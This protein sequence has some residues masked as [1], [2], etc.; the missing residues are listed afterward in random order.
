MAEPHTHT[1]SSDHRSGASPS[2]ERGAMA[3]GRRFG[4]FVV[5]EE[6]GRGGM[7]VVWS[8]YDPQLDRRIALKLVLARGDRQGDARAA[9]RLL[10]E[11]QALARL[12]HP[13]VIAVHDVGIEGE[14]VF[15]AMEYVDGERLDRWCRDR[16]W[17]AIVDAF[18]QAGQG[19]SA[20]HDGG[21]VHRDLKPSNVLVDRS[22]R[23][24]VLDFGLARAI[25]EGTA[26]RDLLEQ[27]DTLADGHAP[28]TA[29]L[30]RGSFTGTPAYASPEQFAGE[31][32]TARSD[33]FGFCV[34]LWECLFGARP[35][36]GE[37][38]SAL[39][40]RVRAGQ[41]D[42]P[43]SSS[44][45]PVWVRRALERGLA[46]DPR[47]RWP[48]MQ[49]LVAILRGDAAVRRRRIGYGLGAIAVVLA[50][51]GG[52]QLHRSELRDACGEEAEVVGTIWNAEIADEL[53]ARF[54]DTGV[55]FAGGT[56]DRTRPWIDANARALREATTEV[57]LAGDLRGELQ[58]STAA[59]AERCL[60]YH[61]DGLERLLR[62]MRRDGVGVVMVSV[63]SAASLT[64]PHDCLD[65]AV[66]AR[67]TPPPDPE[68]EEEAEALWAALDGAILKV[69][70][71]QP[72]RAAEELDTLV[73]DARALGYAP[74]IARALLKRGQVASVLDDRPGAEAWLT[75][76]FVLASATGNDDAAFDAAVA[77]AQVVGAGESALLWLR[78]AEAE[79]ERHGHISPDALADLHAVRMQVHYAA[80]DLDAAIAEARRSVEVSSELLGAEHPSLSR[81]LTNLAQLYLEQGRQ[82]D[83]LASLERALEI[84][85]SSLPPGHPRI[86]VVRSYLAQAQHGLGRDGD[87]RDSL[88]AALPVLDAT[89]PQDPRTAEAHALLESL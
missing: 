48:S 23:V 78:L 73:E 45:V 34:A 19:L 58:G 3:P 36:S 6:L 80:G 40:R 5:L 8:A 47:E 72:S 46:T 64:D 33:Q 84:D 13:N 7:G 86:A 55:D 81:S 82:A 2:T 65:P 89:M 57:C 79:A 29:D 59:A 62:G 20:A 61:R 56:W 18:V 60:G 11:A 35:F 31:V 21:L 42:E 37:T 51:L 88:R 24:R 70:E 66:L 25:G 41:R 77:L 14:R 63:T 30:T 26:D 76:A 85:R 68:I 9:T 75:D 83:A 39:R 53:R 71:S 87:A 69:F 1:E 54:V 17:R 74:L 43:P 50:G 4:R 32:P 15:I 44:S 38:F 52:W 10:R 28:L 49:D 16:P 27:P 22:G 12:A 67:L